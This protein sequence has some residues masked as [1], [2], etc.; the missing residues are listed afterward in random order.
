MWWWKKPED[1]DVFSLDVAVDRS[2]VTLDQSLPPGDHHLGLLQWSNFVSYSFPVVPKFNLQVWVFP[3]VLTLKAGVDEVAELGELQLIHPDLCQ[4]RVSHPAQEKRWRMEI[5]QVV[6]INR[7]LSSTFVQYAE[8]LLVVW[9]LTRQALKESASQLLRSRSGAIVTQL[10]ADFKLLTIDHWPLT[11]Y[12][13]STFD[14]HTCWAIARA[15]GISAQDR[16]NRCSPR[17]SRRP[18]CSLLS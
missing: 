14:Y 11:I 13:L 15:Q 8:Y 18:F 2:H 12:V 7:L 10:I 9:L 1:G 4:R 5:H 16:N 3:Q 17:Y 6:E